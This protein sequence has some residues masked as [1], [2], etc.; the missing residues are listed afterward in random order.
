M[1]EDQIVLGAA[2]MLIRRH[3]HHAPVHVAERIGELAAEGDGMGVA[4]WKA[5]AVYM[6]DILRAGPIQ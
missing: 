4:V 5:I 6:D 1:T 2:I 3:G